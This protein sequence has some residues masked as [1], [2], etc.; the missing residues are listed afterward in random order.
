MKQ[1]KIA[2][3]GAGKSGIACAKLALKFGY[4]VILSEYS[5]KKILET[6]YEFGYDLDQGIKELL[7]GLPKLSTEINY[8]NV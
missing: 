6:G 8:S 2:I 3:L 1:N 7:S 4:R 5:N